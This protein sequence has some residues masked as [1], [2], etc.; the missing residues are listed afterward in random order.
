MISYHILVSLFT[1]NVGNTMYVILWRYIHVY[2]RAI[3]KV[4]YVDGK[5]I[6]KEFFGDASSTVSIIWSNHDKR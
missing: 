1:L 2:R 6:W 4:S 5:G 3:V